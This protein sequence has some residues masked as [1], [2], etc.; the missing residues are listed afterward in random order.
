MFGGF[1]ISNMFCIPNFSYFL[2]SFFIIVV[3]DMILM[4]LW[5]VMSG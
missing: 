3:I 4:N 5:V 2:I 1:L